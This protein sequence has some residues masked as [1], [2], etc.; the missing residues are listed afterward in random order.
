MGEGVQFTA[1]GITMTPRSNLTTIEHM[2]HSFA[3]V[4]TLSVGQRVRDLQLNVRH[5]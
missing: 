3:S 1:L 5:N 2:E 4:A